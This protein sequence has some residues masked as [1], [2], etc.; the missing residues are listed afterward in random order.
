[1]DDVASYI[2]IGNDDVC[3]GVVNDPLNGAIGNP[4]DIDFIEG[5]KI[6]LTFNPAIDELFQLTLYN[7]DG[8]SVTVTS[9]VNGVPDTEEITVPAISEGSNEVVPV[10]IEILN[11]VAVEIEFTNAGALCSVEICLDDNKTSSPSSEPT[12]G[13]TSGPTSAPTSEPPTSEPTS[14]PTSGPT[15]APTR[16]CDALVVDFSFDDNSVENNHC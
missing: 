10:N 13:P 4:D 7:G 16:K 9:E 5:G 11:V 3:I 12:S 1:M 2:D 14:A 15:S 6:V 8:A